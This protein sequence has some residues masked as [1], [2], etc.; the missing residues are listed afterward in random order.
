MKMGKASATGSF[1][2]FIG[3]IASTVMLSISSI[4]VGIIINPGEFGLYTIAIIPAATFILFQDWGVGSAMTKFCANYRGEKREGELR[5]IIVSGLTFKAITGLSLT[6]L[7]LLTANFVASTI[8]NNPELTFLVT[9]VSVTIFFDAIYGSSLSVFVGFERME[10][11]TITMIV[12]ATVRSLLS[13][14]LVYLGFG[15]VGVVVGFTAASAASGVTAVVLLYFIIFRKLPLGSVNKV[16]MFQ[17]LK[18]LLIYGIPLSIALIIGGVLPQVSNFMMASFVDVVMIGN[19]GIA[20]NFAI[21]LSFFT[22]PII[23]VLFPAFSKLD[24]LVDKQI[25]KTVF[26]SSVK[27]SSLFLVPATLALM[28]LSAPLINTIFGD[29]WPFAPLF[30]T[31]SIIGNLVVLLGNLSYNRL[32]VATGETTLLMKLNVLTLCTGVPLAFL[33]I[34]PLGILGVIIVG[35]VAGVPTMIIGLHWTWKRY[36]TKADL[37]KSA[38]IFF[39]SAI[40]GATTYLFLNTFVTAPWIMLLSGA[41]LFL[42]IYIVSVSL[43]GAINRID[44]K[45]LRVM[46]SELGPISKLLQLLLNLIEKPIILKEKLSNVGN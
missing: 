24:P 40:A 41:I 10:L 16:T 8:F 13:P 34:P 36:E 15:A 45:N 9:L 28:V 30:L 33:L 46:F 26:E 17:T 20:A 32:L 42:V 2:L 25:L 27:Y 14:L 18:P 7:S 11:S 39:A 22:L 12:S 38:R 44:I 35:N 6:F 21:F 4:I 3:R 19:L 31:W 29:K 37:R 43:V 5:S 23:T 1:Q